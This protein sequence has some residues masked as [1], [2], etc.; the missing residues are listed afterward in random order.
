MDDSERNAL[1]IQQESLNQKD[2]M[3]SYR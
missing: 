3:S 1:L 2:K